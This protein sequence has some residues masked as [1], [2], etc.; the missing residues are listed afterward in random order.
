MYIGWS[1]SIFTNSIKAL[2][3]IK[4][5]NRAT[6]GRAILQD[7]SIL[8]RQKTQDN[9]H[10]RIAWIPRHYRILGNEE[11]NTVA[12]QATATKGK[13]TAPVERRIRELK[14]VL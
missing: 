10:L 4:A 11:A 9:W 12:R 6:S 8:I 5:G 1:C 13:P 3:A 2:S 7:I 14:G